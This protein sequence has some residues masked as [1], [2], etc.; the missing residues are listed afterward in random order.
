[1]SKYLFNLYA[2]QPIF[3]IFPVREEKKGHFPLPS[4]FLLCLH[5]VHKYLQVD[6]CKNRMQSYY[7]VNKTSKRMNHCNFQVIQIK[8][9]RQCFVVNHLNLDTIIA[10]NSKRPIQRIVINKY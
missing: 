3:Q 1:M 8:V 9:M 7:E 10:L 5:S 2:K 4:I 6:I